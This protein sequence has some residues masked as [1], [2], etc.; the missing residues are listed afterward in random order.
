MT[1]EPGSP[2]GQD[3]PLAGEL[4]AVEPQPGGTGWSYSVYQRI[5]RA[6]ITNRRPG[7]YELYGVY[8]VRRAA[9][10][11]DLFTQWEGCQDGDGVVTGRSLLASSCDL[12]PYIWSPAAWFTEISLFVT[13]DES[14]RDGRGPAQE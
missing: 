13:P 8:G 4:F 1:A 5:G 9:D 7:G 14:R 6:K 2:A 3:D 10:G 11:W 12:D